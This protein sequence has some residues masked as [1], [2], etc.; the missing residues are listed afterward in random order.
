MDETLVDNNEFQLGLLSI[1]FQL[2]D[3]FNGILASLTGSFVSG[4]LG[5]FGG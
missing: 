3:I 4:V 5:L 1:I 2:I